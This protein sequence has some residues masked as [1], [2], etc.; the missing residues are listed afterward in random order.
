MPKM[1]KLNFP[2]E[3]LKDINDIQISKFFSFIKK[4]AKRRIS[5]N[6]C[7]IC[8]TQTKLCNSHSVPKFVLKVIADNGNLANINKIINMPGTNSING[9]NNAKTF[10]MLCPKCDKEF[11]S[12]YEE[13]KNWNSQPTDKMLA[14]IV[15]K[16][17]LREIYKKDIELELFKTVRDNDKVQFGNLDYIQTLDLEGFKKEYN[18]AKK[19]INQTKRYYISWYHK[20]DYI[21]PIALQ[22]RICLYGGFDDEIINQ[23]YELEKTPKEMYICLFPF[24]DHSIIMMFAKERDTTYRNFFKQLN[25]M[26]LDEQ[27]QTVSY[28]VFT[29]LEEYMCSPKLNLNHDMIKQSV[30]NTDIY[31]EDLS[32]KQKILNTVKEYSLSKRKDF[33]N[34][35]SKKYAI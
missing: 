29:Y 27:L 18:Y 24:S 1:M 33:P 2:K 4:E 16:I 6:K 30:E 14:Q 3:E 21:I 15:A 17:Y 31:E 25:K 8:G 32:K 9:L 26:P 19:S 34:I 22:G 10:T 12:D 20:L 13:I 11:F 23:V 7:E 35:L 5:N 28:I